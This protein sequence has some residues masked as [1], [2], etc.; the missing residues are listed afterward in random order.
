MDQY[1][2][3]QSRTLWISY[4]QL[5]VPLGTMIGYVIEAYFINTTDDVKLLLYDALIL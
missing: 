4:L 2:I 5:G 1:G 3:N